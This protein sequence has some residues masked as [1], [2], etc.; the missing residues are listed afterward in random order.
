M[1]NA[2]W[3]TDFAIVVGVL[4]MAWPVFAAQEGHGGSPQAQQKIAALKESMALSQRSL[5]QY[6]W[7]ESTTVSLKGEPKSQ[8]SATCQYG[9]DGTVQKSPMFDSAANGG[10]KK[11]ARGLKGRVIEK[12]KDEMQD[13]MER[14]ASLI[15][16]YVPPDPEKMKE[17]F[18]GG[19]ATIQ[20]GQSG[21]ATLSFHDYAKPGDTLSLTIDSATSTMQG[22]VVKTYLD[23][24]SDAVNLAIRFDNL[25]DGT[26]FMAE[27][28]LDVTAK[29]IQV[30]TTNSGH[31]KL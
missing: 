31:H 19:Q 25:G 16:R 1:R 10:E 11:K 5:R 30:K 3:T 18:Q 28:V 12:K 6:A 2:G 17:A 21:I 20:P 9:P 8:K 23:E 14:A 27:T 22:I 7:T 26:N 4:V 15:K 29:Q 13:Y 24:K